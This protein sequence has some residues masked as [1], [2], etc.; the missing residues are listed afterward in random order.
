M[1]PAVQTRGQARVALIGSLNQVATQVQQ[2]PVLNSQT[3]AIL[4]LRPSQLSDKACNPI[5]ESALKLSDF[6]DL[7]ECMQ[8]ER[9]NML[10]LFNKSYNDKK[11]LGF[12]DDVAGD[13]ALFKR[14]EQWLGQIMRTIAR[15]GI[16]ALQKVFVQEDDNSPSQDVFRSILCTKEMEN[17]A[18]GMLFS[19]QWA[20]KVWSHPLV[21][22]LVALKFHFENLNEVTNV[23]LDTE[24]AE[25]LQLSTDSSIQAIIQLLE[26]VIQPVAKTYTTVEDLLAYL[27]ASIQFEIVQH[28]SRKST[29]NGQA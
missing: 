18:S 25:I 8:W 16:L 10:Q 29:T 9:Q 5:W 3:S 21:Q 28:R 27:K 23:N 14:H 22:A 2:T 24:L 11:A 1:Q 6:G 7:S 12:S 20:T 15:Q 26:K 19:N 4:L 13:A 17:V